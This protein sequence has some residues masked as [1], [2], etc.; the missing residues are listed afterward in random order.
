MK[1]NFKRIPKMTDLF[2]D[3]I[4]D[5]QKE[6]EF[7]S[8]PPYEESEYNKLFNNLY[9]NNYERDL[10]VN[11]LKEQNFKFGNSQTT[12]ESIDRLKR[13]DTFVI[14]TGQQV[15]LF[16]GPMYTVYKAMTSINLARY[17][18]MTTP[19][20][21]LP[22]FWVE[23][24]DHDFDEVKSSNIIDK[25]NNLLTLTYE[26]ET[27]FQGQSAGSVVL[28][29]GINRLTEKYA[30]SIHD[31]EY[32]NDILAELRKCYT[33]G[34]TMAEAFSRWL[35][36]LLGRYGL[37][38]VDPSNQQLKR[39]AL[40]VYI[41]SLE[42]HESQINPVFE[43]TNR[44]LKE[45]GY[46]CQVGH[47]QDTLDFFY[48]NPNRLPFI[49]Q[50]GEYNLKG[51]RTNLSKQQLLE[52]LNNE[53]ESF[54]PNVILRPQVQDYLFP[55]AAYVAGPAE[56]AYFAQFKDLYEIF[57]NTMPIIYPRKSLSILEGKI[58]KIMHKYCIST[59]N[60][61]GSRESLEHRI[62]KE[63]MPEDLQL[64]IEDSR[65]GIQANLDELEKAATAYSPELKSVLG[66]VKS[67]IIKDLTY[68]E[69]KITQAEEQKNQIVREQ[70]DKV[71]TNILPNGSL[72]E[73][74]LNILSFLYKYHHKMIYSLMELTCCKHE[75]DHIV[76]KVD[77]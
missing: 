8:I 5:F 73:R 58:D 34:K 19:Y 21:F 1:I 62:I 4:Y 60:I 46:H 13:R 75:I 48:S 56:I 69:S 52:S 77:V 11:V 31:T 22:L 16:G 55:T 42:M 63:Q 54:S 27:P 7:Y 72:Q 23:G 24:E 76:W 18:T 53:I 57:G 50:N 66:K 14:I 3:Y 28:D 25:D 65:K 67:R 45:A 36:Y 64:T 70:I 51:T 35:V 71:F 43:R 15:G 39:A 47:R 38:I 40:P 59:K 32:N 33:P 74:T 49:K 41:K 12:I 44:N 61:F 37:I 29:E 6:K 68:A 9:N 10:I 2:L 30:E 26:P 17:L 20:T